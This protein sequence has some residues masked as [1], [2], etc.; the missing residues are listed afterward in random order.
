M[1]LIENGIQSTKIIISDKDM[2][3]AFHFMDQP[4][5]LQEWYHS[6]DDPDS[7]SQYGT[8]GHECLLSARCHKFLGVGSLI[9]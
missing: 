1:D 8:A 5:L 2:V 6:S 7:I 9:S 3:S 4:A